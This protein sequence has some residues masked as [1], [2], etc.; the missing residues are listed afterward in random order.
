VIRTIAL[1]YSGGLDTSIIVPWLKERYGA[2]VICVAAD[3]G[4]GNEL[5]GVRAKAIA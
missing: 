5:E 4:Q 2:R 1:A 3:I